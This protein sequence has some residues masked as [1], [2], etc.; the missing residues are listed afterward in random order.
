MRKS[1]LIILCL[2]HC[3]LLQSQVINI[4]SRRLESKQQG[5]NGQGEFGY[6]FIQNQNSF[7]NLN[8]RINFLHQK[9][10][11]RWFII[12]D[13][14]LIQSSQG[15]FENAGYQ[16]V[17]YN[18]QK[19]ERLSYE[20]YA[21]LQFSKQMRL[22]PR[23]VLGGGPRYKIVEG[24]SVKIFSGVSLLVEHER[25]LNPIGVNSNERLSAYL[26]LLFYQIPGVTID[27]LVMYQPR[28]IRF[29]DRRIQTEL[30]FDFPV[31]AHLQCRFAA[32]V[33][34]DTKPP[35]GV[36]STFTNMR[37]GIIYNF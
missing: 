16:H 5:W 34:N 6:A 18:H 4:E 2:F 27:L 24:D 22:Y 12:S 26:S 13:L 29:S 25:M 19:S 8:T 14:S 33:F 31:S 15:D 28:L 36:P 7:S 32:T 1:W 11:H 10:I 37:S 21:Q 17:R 20:A 35:E 30:R 3:L 23:Y 9:D